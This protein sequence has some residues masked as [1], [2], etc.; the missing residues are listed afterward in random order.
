MRVFVASDDPRLAY[1]LLGLELDCPESYVLSVDVVIAHRRSLKE[2][3][4]AALGGK[5][6]AQDHIPISGSER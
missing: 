6:T 1:Q 3:S 4:V 2:E 5:L